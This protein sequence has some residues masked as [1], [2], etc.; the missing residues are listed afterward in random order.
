MRCERATGVLLAAV[1]LCAGPPPRA[2]NT[3]NTKA[4]KVRLAPVAMDLTMVSNI[5]GSGAAT[6]TLTGTKLTITGTF[7]GLRSPA[8]IAQIRK[9]P[10]TGMRGPVLFDLTI[11]KSTSGTVSGTVD[12]TPT[13][14][15]DPE[16]G[17]LYIQIHSEKAPDGNLWGWLLPENRHVRD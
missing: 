14:V 5:A 16:K 13:Q 2:Q 7:D 12:L 11:A 9:G 15:T 4:Y 3:Q 1:L 8:T 17:R 10:V 6:A